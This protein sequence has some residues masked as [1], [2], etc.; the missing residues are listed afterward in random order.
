MWRRV[1]LKNYRSIESAEVQLAPFTVIVGPNGSGKTNFVDA[2]ALASEMAF[3]AASAVQSRGG[4]MALRRSGTEDMAP[5]Q[6]IIRTADT[7]ELLDTT[8]VE[9]SFS[10][11][12]SQDTGW[13]FLDEIHEVRTAGQEEQRLTRP[14]RVVAEKPPLLIDTW[15]DFLPPTASLMLFVRQRGY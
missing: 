6:G 2:L 11:V 1:A 4:F 10:L 15:M 7:R 8:Y 12:P 5:I 14:R 3:D 9:H 13:R